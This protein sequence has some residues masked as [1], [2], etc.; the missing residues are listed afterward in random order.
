MRLV[1]MKQSISTA[2]HPQTDGQ[3][4]RANA[5]LEDMFRAYVSPEQ[6]D[7]DECLDAAEFAVN[8][9]WQEAVRATPFELNYGHHP[10]TPVNVIVQENS[11]DAVAKAFVDRIAEGIQRACA[12]VEVVQQPYKQYADSGRIDVRFEVGDEV[13]LSAKNL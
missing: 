9:A 10:N 12:C 4:E 11:K 2:F 6:Y 1:G 13:M 7:W 5:I 8:N 3:T